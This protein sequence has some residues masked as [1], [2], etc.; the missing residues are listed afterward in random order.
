MGQS[1]WK[2][3]LWFGGVGFYPV[4]SLQ[5][6]F[7]SKSKPRGASPARRPPWPGQEEEPPENQLQAEGPKAAVPSV[8]GLMPGTFGQKRGQAMPA[9]RI[10]G[11]YPEGSHRLE[12]RDPL[13]RYLG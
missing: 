5:E 10:S 13:D 9:P 12:F 1:G 6:I 2:R 7:A 3:A 11:Y 4:K 8:E